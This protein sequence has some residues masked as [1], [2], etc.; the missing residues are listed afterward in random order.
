MKNPLF[1]CTFLLTKELPVLI[2]RT[3]GWQQL[4][5]IPRGLIE[6][7]RF[8]YARKFRKKQRRVLETLALDLKVERSSGVEILWVS[9]GWDPQ[10]FWAM[11]PRA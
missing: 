1:G 10:G 5:A 3:L 8:L 4:S 2:S 11:V 9:T 6:V 7:L